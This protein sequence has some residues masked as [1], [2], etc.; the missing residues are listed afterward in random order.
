MG[1][2]KGGQGGNGRRMYKTRVGKKGFAPILRPHDH[3]VAHRDIGKQWLKLWLLS[4]L[5]LLKKYYTDFLASQPPFRASGQQLRHNLRGKLRH[6][7][8]PSTQ[9]HAVNSGTNQK[10]KFCGTPRSS[11]RLDKMSTWVPALLG[12]MHLG[13]TI[14]LYTWRNDILI[15]A[16]ISAHDK[17]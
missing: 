10:G 9:Y 2:R 15:R 1:K 7:C 4:T 8:S 6:N 5:L 12:P 13:R 16:D 3:G 17:Y 11:G 14:N